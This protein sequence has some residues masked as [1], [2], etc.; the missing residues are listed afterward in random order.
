[1]FRTIPGAHKIPRI[2]RFVWASKGVL[3]DGL[4]VLSQ[5]LTSE[6]CLIFFFTTWGLNPGLY[7]LGKCSNINLRSGVTTLN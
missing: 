7:K 5:E 6:H 3:F 1:M 4:L 2:K